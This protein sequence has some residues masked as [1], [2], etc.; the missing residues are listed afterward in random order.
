L[1]PTFEQLEWLKQGLI[2]SW[3]TQE[4]RGRVLYFHHPPYVTELT[5]WDQGQTMEVRYHLRRV[6]DAVAEAVGELP[7]G[8]PIVDLVLSGHAH[9][10]EHLYTG[11]TGHADSHIN[12][13]VCGGS[14]YSLRRQRAEGSDL[15]ERFR[16]NEGDRIRQVAKSRLLSVGMVMAQRRGDPIRLSELMS[17]P[18]APPSWLLDPLSPNDWGDSGVIA[19]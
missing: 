19:I 9:C 12:W 4:V 1:L 2:E 15:S 10:L 7:Q 16:D 5:K 11:D 8:R 13:I 14:G 6:L 18:V 17:K 3:N